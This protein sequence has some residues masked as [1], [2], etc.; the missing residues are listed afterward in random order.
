MFTPSRDRTISLDHFPPNLHLYDSNGRIF[1]PPGLSEEF[2]QADE[3]SAGNRPP[4]QPQL[5]LLPAVAQ[6]EP[7]TPATTSRRVPVYQLRCRSR[8]CFTRSSAG[9]SCSSLSLVPAAAGSAASVS[10]W[11]S[12]KQKRLFSCFFAASRDL[13]AYFSF[14]QLFHTFKNEPISFLAGF[15][16][17]SKKKCFTALLSRRGARGSRLLRAPGSC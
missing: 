5:A 8:A 9:L 10:S 17:S 2:L 4:L 7:R 15:S 11:C 1:F 6:R 12:A 16:F 3:H 13:T 14:P